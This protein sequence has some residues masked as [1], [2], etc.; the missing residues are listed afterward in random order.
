MGA[1]SEV[2]ERLQGEDIVKAIKAQRLQRYAHIR[3]EE[4]KAV[5]KL[6]EETRTLEEQEED[7]KAMGGMGIEG[8]HNWR[9]K[10][11][12]N[13]NHGRELQGGK[14]SEKLE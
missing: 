14:T 6:A 5:K 7:R 10:I 12:R 1:N 13:G 4:E 9:G 3:M 11:H 8:I 2:Q